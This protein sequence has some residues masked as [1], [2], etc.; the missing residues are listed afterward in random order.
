V[1]F[2]EILYEIINSVVGLMVVQLLIQILE[3]ELK[4]FEVREVRRALN[5]FLDLHESVLPIFR[6]ILS[7]YLRSFLVK[8]NVHSLGVFLVGHSVLRDLKDHT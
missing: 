3:T 4:L 1:H 8:T 2:D 5:F 7:C 6:N